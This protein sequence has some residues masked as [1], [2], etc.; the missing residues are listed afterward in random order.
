MRKR[1]L[2]AAAA[3]HPIPNTVSCGFAKAFLVAA[4]LALIAA[5]PAWAQTF[6]KSFTDDPVMPGGT[7]TLEYTI[8]NNSGVALVDL[9]FTDDFDAALSGLSATGLPA[10]LCGAGSTLT[11]TT[12]ISLVS[13]ALTDGES[14]TFDVTSERPRRRHAVDLHE[15]VEPTLRGRRRRRRVR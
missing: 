13:G 8:N 9:N 7:V 1:I 2:P 15:H 12:T 5:A 4:A 10:S 14:C 3:L 11:G 6:T